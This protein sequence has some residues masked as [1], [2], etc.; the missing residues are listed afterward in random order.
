MRLV[1]QE[2]RQRFVNLN[3][4]PTAGRPRSSRSW[5]SHLEDRYEELLANGGEKQDAQRLALAELL[6]SNL[7]TRE[8]SLVERRAPQ[9]SVVLGGW[10][11]LLGR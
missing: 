7:L 5:P 6:A 10:S 2:F 4:E 8:L 1:E 11:T 9:E 3:V